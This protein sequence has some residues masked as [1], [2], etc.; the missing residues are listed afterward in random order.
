MGIGFAY[1]QF[2]IVFG[3]ELALAAF[4]GAQ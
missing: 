3:R 1:M 4:F 2:E